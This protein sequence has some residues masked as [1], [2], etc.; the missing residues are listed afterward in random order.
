MVYEKFKTQKDKRNKNEEKILTALHESPKKFG[1]LLK[2]TELS[3]MGLINILKRLLKAEKIKKIIYNGNEAYDLT[4]KG[5]KAYENIWYLQ[6]YIEELKENKASYIS[7][8]FNN[9]VD[10]DRIFGNNLNDSADFLPSPST[11]ITFIEKE[12]LKKLL[13]KTISNPQGEYVMSFRFNMNIFINHLSSIKNFVESISNDSDIFENMANKMPSEWNSRISYY[14]STIQAIENL[15]DDEKMIAKVLENVSKVIKK[16]KNEI[17]TQYDYHLYEAI[18]RDIE[19]NITPIKDDKIKDQLIIKTKDNDSE[20]R[21]YIIFDY[22][23][24]LSV[25]NLG[26]D[27][28]IKRIETTSNEIKSM[29]NKGEI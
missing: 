8:G 2:V 13:N 29:I 15:Y 1:E 19:N 25:L 22:L 14:L 6:Y 7:E 17:F 27:E 9:G 11:I 18:K 28:L 5:N 23:N 20:L 26:D 24:L 16:H 12:T 3:S 10:I 21:T 4:E